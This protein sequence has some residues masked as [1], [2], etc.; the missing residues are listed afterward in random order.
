[1][2]VPSF[3]ELHLAGP[4]LRAVS[5]E[6]YERPTPIQVR[7]IPH[8]LEGRDLLGWAQTGSGKT[9]AFALPIIQRLSAS[10]P[11]GAGEAGRKQ[12]DRQPGR[13]KAGRKR[14]KGHPAR[15]KA[16]AVVLSP[17]RELAVQIAESFRVYGRHVGPS[18]ALVHGG[19]SQVPQV[20]ALRRG[21]DV[22]VATPGRLLDLIRQRHVRLDAVEVF[23]LD[24][25][26]RMLDMGFIP[27]VLRII[28]MLPRRRQSLF[29]GA[30]MPPRVM[31]L[32]DDMLTEPVVVDLA[33]RQ[34]TA[35]NIDQK[36]MLVERENK[37]KLLCRMLEAPEVVR[38][39]VFTRTKHKADSL[40]RALRRE[41]I[42]A[43]AIHGNRPQAARQKAL[44]GFR[45]GRTHVLVAT[46]VAARGIDV[47]G[48][49]H[50]F[51]FEI[52]VEAEMYVH[53]IGRT[54]R[55][56]AAG[57]A[58]SFCDVSE[59]SNLY[60]IEKLIRRPLP[61]VED[62][63]FRSQVPYIA[64]GSLVVGSGRRGGVRPSPRRGRRL[65]RRV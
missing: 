32:A 61:V 45:E 51:N 42:R 50:V 24:E 62:H 22:L 1:M 2:Q 63:P 26:D 27:D 31:A 56:G 18:V 5:D 52:P 29:F 47:E 33:P 35:D 19:V 57:V 64:A 44:D 12:P 48:V 14:S 15:G 43:E 4:L 59:R 53:R 34:V 37:R 7:A 9:A 6:G 54:A 30:T 49:T 11:S 17:T 10:R 38:A 28:E 20:R 55:A 25:A 23:V 36:V 13:G 58:Y 60:D 40:A 8:L 21:V 16:R 39:L 41:R 3:R 65:M 46:D